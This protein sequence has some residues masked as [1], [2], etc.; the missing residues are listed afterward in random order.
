[1]AGARVDV[2]SE[3]GRSHYPTESVARARTDGQGRARVVPWPGDS[4][5]DPRLSAA[6]ASR[7]SPP[8]STSTGPR[9]PCNTSV[10]V[11]LRRGVVVR[12]RLI[13]DPAGTPVAGG[14]VVYHQTHRDNPRHRRPAVDRGRQRARR[15]VH[16]GRPPGPGH[17]LVQGPGADYLHVA[18][19]F[20]EM[21]VGIRPSF[22]M[23]PDAHA[24]LDIKDGEATH[25]LELRLRRGVTVTGRVVAPD[26]QPVAEAF[27]FGRS[28][29][30]YR[31]VR[32]PP[33]GRSTA[34][35][36]RSR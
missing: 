5:P 12:G 34:T 11:K 27:A 20:G 2:R 32:L 30:P 8:G 22:H 26:G 16:H 7:T 4:V 31:R 15:H 35:R 33:G 1:M 24:I 3:E 25:P 21:G 29:M 17:L 18:T 23:Y 19:S 9:G 6:R 10:E 28:Y 14:W 36:R 13:E